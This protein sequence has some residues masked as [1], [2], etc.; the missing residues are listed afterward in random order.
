MEEEGLAHMEVLAHAQEATVGV[1]DLSFGLLLDLLAVL[2]FG[3]QEDGHAEDDTFASATIHGRGH[4]AI[5]PFSGLREPVP[6]GR[7]V[8][9]F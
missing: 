8:V 2:V 6:R 4:D 5:L 1:N 9:F 7:V 3:D